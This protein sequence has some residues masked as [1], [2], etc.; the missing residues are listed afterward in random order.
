VPSVEWPFDPTETFTGE[1]LARAYELR[2]FVSPAP[3]L[4]R[5]DHCPHVPP[6]PNARVCIEEIAW[7]L[8][9]QAEIEAAS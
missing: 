7:Y 6:C 3:T 8:R 2:R 5:R 4:K 9:H 1:E